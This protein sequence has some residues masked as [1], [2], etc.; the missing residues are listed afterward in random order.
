MLLQV[1]YQGCLGYSCEVLTRSYALS[2]HLPHGE[3]VI[4][5]CP[6]LGRQTPGL[7]HYTGGLVSFLFAGGILCSP[8]LKALGDSHYNSGGI[9]IPSGSCCLHSMRFLLTSWPPLTC[10]ASHSVFTLAGHFPLSVFGLQKSQS[11][12]VSNVGLSLVRVTAPF[13]EG[14]VKPRSQE[15]KSFFFTDSGHVS[16]PWP[17]PWEWHPV[18]AECWPLPV[19]SHLL[20][21]GL[22]P[23]VFWLD[24][25]LGVLWKADFQL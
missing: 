3:W 10:I 16:C 14:L 17:G 12:W 13:L 19:H 18:C 5:G 25:R 20:G 2:N 4:L 6:S 7:S 8:L 15:G 9:R 23:S 21:E 11:F 24:S 22:Y 1:P